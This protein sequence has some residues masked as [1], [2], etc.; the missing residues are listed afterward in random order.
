MDK[1]NE[2]VP[3]QHYLSP[4]QIKPNYSFAKLLSCPKGKTALCQNYNKQQKNFNFF[5]HRLAFFTHYTNTAFRHD[6]AE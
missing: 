1:K 2:A 6:F 3:P 4:N 5:F